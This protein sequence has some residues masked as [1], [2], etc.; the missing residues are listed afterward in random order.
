MKKRFTL[1]GLI[2]GMLVLSACGNDTG[3]TK[4]QQTLIDSAVIS[5][6]QAI[7]EL[8]EVVTLPQVI[9]MYENE[10]EDLPKDISGWFAAQN[11]LGDIVN[12]KVSQDVDF[13]GKKVVTV[14]TV[15]EGS[16]LGPD[17]KPRQAEVIFT[18][19]QSKEEASIITNVKYTFGEL[20]KNAGLNTLLG[21][22]TVF[23]V[24][25][26]IMI[27]IMLF[28]IPSK[29]KK[30]NG[31]A[32]KKAS[33]VDKVVEQIAANEEAQEDD[34]EL[35]AV[36]SAAIAAYEGSNASGDGYVV[37]SIRRIR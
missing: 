25:I 3:Y 29:I 14:T 31:D 24:L 6:D 30:K 23:T 13:D 19:D 21:M 12:P 20:M 37:R 22:G 9:E 18:Y 32:E 28:E 1:I 2:A 34:T 8:Q 35:I 27:V 33:G 10:D 36:I 26:L 7:I 5:A 16:K 17:G 4:K 11:E 15:V